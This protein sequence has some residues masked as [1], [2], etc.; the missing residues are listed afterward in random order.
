M[1]RIAVLDDYLDQYR[2]LADWDSLPSSCDVTFF[3]KHLGW[4]E[5]KVAE[6]LKDFDVIVGV[7][8]RTPF[9]ESQIAKL[10]NLK[11]LM[12]TGMNNASFD[13]DG[14]RKHDVTICGTRS[15][16]HPTIEHAWAMILGLF[17]QLP[18]KDKAMRDGGWQAGLSIGLRG[19][20]LGVLGLGRLG[21]QVAQIGLAFGMDVIAWSQNLT[22][23]KCDE[24]GTIRCVDKDALFKESDVLTI[25]Y[26]LSKRSEGL[27]GAKEFGLMKP[28]A[29]IVNT[30]RGP[31]IDEQALL[32]ALMG[33]KIA[34]AGI[35]VYWQEPLPAGHPIRKLDNTL[36]TGHVGYVMKENLELNMADMVEN[37]KAW[38]DGKPV[39]VMN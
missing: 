35:D 18:A 11:L 27:I 7:R 32:D 6:A 9:P 2:D 28:T 10:P 22:Q 25:H 31:I 29:Y 37:I 17:K 3:T 20:T 19:K 24:V 12:T 21:S 38:L 5:D 33:N 13:N 34:G 30:S 36:L 8:E 23:E 16:S 26:K 15:L 4:D 1:T 39:R 14:A